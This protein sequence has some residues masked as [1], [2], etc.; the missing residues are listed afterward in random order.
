[1]IF[2]NLIRY[3]EANI[4]QQAS[5]TVGEL[6]QKMIDLGAQ[7]SK[8]VGTAMEVG[9]LLAEFTPEFINGITPGRIGW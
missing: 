2:K 6:L 5:G 4:T 8:V 9:D 3:L 1:M 7:G